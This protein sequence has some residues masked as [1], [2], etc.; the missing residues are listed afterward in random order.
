MTIGRIPQYMAVFRTREDGSKTG[1]KRNV[2]KSLTFP[3]GTPIILFGP[4][5]RGPD[6]QVGNTSKDRVDALEI[7]MV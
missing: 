6:C 2:N 7:D 5:E 3:N 1:L 4:R